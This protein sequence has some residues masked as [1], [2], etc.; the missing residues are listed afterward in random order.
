MDKFSL[1]GQTFGLV[2]NI[3]QQIKD[4]KEGIEAKGDYLAIEG[5]LI[6]FWSEKGCKEFDF[7]NKEANLPHLVELLMSF[8]KL[9]RVVVDLG[10]SNKSINDSILFGI[11]HIFGCVLEERDQNEEMNLTE[12]NKNKENIFLTNGL[13]INHWMFQFM[14]LIVKSNQHRQIENI[15]HQATKILMIFTKIRINLQIIW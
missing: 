12:E 11:G 13:N 15:L 2:I 9:T 4:S 3:N 1:R 10:F 14:S 5:L 6:T 8:L 7:K